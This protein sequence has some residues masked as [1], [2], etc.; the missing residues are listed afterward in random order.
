M[1]KYILNGENY[2]IYASSY[3]EAQEAVAMGRNRAAA[4][5]EM[6]AAGACIDC[7]SGTLA[8]CPKCRAEA[9]QR[10]DARRKNR[11]EVRKAKGY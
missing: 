1:A 8:A 6:L 3:A 7:L 5:Q 2:G 9:R 10:A 11:Q 4:V